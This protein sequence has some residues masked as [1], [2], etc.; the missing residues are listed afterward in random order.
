MG[1]FA[2]LLHPST[3]SPSEAKAKAKSTPHATSSLPP[4][5][6]SPATR[7]GST[8]F[9]T[10]LSTPAPSHTRA[11]SS[12]FP[13][14]PPPPST[15]S[16]ITS[17]I[18]KKPWKKDR[19]K[20]S[21]KGKGKGTTIEDGGPGLGLGMGISDEFGSTRRPI[22]IARTETNYV[23]APS[24]PAPD[25]KRTTMYFAGEAVPS[26]PLSQSFSVS[27]N[28]DDRD[29]A[30][31]NT[32]DGGKRGV[33]SSGRTR[34]QSISSGEFTREG[35]ILGRLTFEDD[36]RLT[37][38]RRDAEPEPDEE[39]VMAV[40]GGKSYNSTIII[41]K[42]DLRSEKPLELSGS[43]VKSGGA[44]EEEFMEVLESAEK[45][46]KFWKGK[47]RARR[48]SKSASDHADIDRAGSPTPR[49]A[50][51]STAAA[52]LDLTVT[53]HSIDLVQPRPQQLRRPSSS[54]FHNPFHRSTSRTSM[55]MDLDKSPVVDDGSFQLKGFRH[56][57]GMMEV[58]GAG[59]LEGYLSHV[60]RE[61]VVA[62]ALDKPTTPA[63]A[64]PLEANSA[65][66]PSS[67][68]MR[69][70]PRPLSRPPSVANSLASLDEYIAS[71]SKV[72][73]AAFRKGIRRPSE[74]ITTMSDIGHGTACASVVDNDDLPLGML[75]KQHPVRQKS[76][77]S[78][79]SMRELGEATD[80]KASASP[81]L[82]FTVQRH[83]LNGGGSPGTSFAVRS[84][85]TTNRLESK[86]ALGPQ[87]EFRP[88]SLNSPQSPHFVGQADDQLKKDGSSRSLSPEA[89]SP[90]DSYFA[91]NAPG[92]TE[93]VTISP[94]FK[95][96]GP[97]VFST[98]PTTITRIIRSPAPLTSPER[99]HPPPVEPIVGP[100][101]GD[102][103]TGSLT[104]PFPPDQ[105]PATPPKSPA[106]LPDLSTEP[107]MSPGGRKRLSLL[108]EPLRI[109]SGLFAS[110]S[111]QGEDGLDPTLVV[112]SMRI[113]GGDT[114]ETTM[115]RPASAQGTKRLD[116]QRSHLT[117]FDA[118][119]ATPGTQG[120][121]ASGLKIEQEGK[122]R[123][124]LSERLAGISS[125]ALNSNTSRA[126]PG[127]KAIDTSGISPER[128]LTDNNMS[129]TSNSTASPPVSATPTLVPSFAGVMIGSRARQ[130]SSS[131][132]ESEETNESIRDRY[133]GNIG[134]AKGASTV[135]ENGRRHPSGPRKPSTASNRNRA[136]YPSSV[137]LT[138]RTSHQHFP[139]RK[140]TPNAHSESDDDEPLATLKYK[141]S[142]S[143]LSVDSTSQSPHVNDQ[144]L[145]VSPV[146]TTTTRIA[147]KARFLPG[148]ESTISIRPV[149]SYDPSASVDVRAR[150][151]LSHSPPEGRR[152]TPTQPQRE[153][154]TTYVTPSHL[155][156]PGTS[157]LRPVQDGQRIRREREKGVESMRRKT[158]SPDSYSS[159]SGTT[160][161]MDSGPYQPMTPKEEKA[162]SRESAGGSPGDGS[163]K[164]DTVTRIGSPQHVSPPQYVDD[165]KRRHSPAPAMQANWP[166]YNSDRGMGMQMNPHMNP[167]AIR[168]IMKQQWQ[169]QFMAAA[170]RASE[171][172][173]ERASS[174]S[175]HSPSAHRQPTTTYQGYGTPPPM[176][177]P[178][179]PG[180]GMS[181]YGGGLSTGYP[182]A[183][184]GY[185]YDPTFV[186]VPL[187]GQNAGG[188]Y[189]YGY[190][191]N[192]QSVFGG[193]FGPPTNLRHHIPTSGSNPNIRTLVDATSLSQ[194]RGHTA[195]RG[196]TTKSVYGGVAA[197]PP[198]PVA[199]T[200]GVGRGRQSTSGEWAG[201]TA[202]QKGGRSKQLIN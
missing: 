3:S 118:G 33:P 162:G 149:R 191:T 161:T 46:N 78:L 145:P 153:Q 144:A 82:S 104:L 4:S 119:T 195:G 127:L 71:S 179:Y 105:M 91:Q 66:S 12:Y 107:A 173:W 9:L 51:A 79:S 30:H 180:M 117:L 7:S 21:G 108:D 57:S 61:S 65:I 186:P 43:S 11:T 2:R 141:A 5:P 122:V 81:A 53:R 185:G 158:A 166:L 131:D 58:E 114:E 120:E 135:T 40:T 64:S 67:T 202:P 32:D 101:P 55:A 26:S 176:P 126:A 41:D 29:D 88:S 121:H 125:L 196:G 177:M 109:I 37:D 189:G 98:P 160:T 31:I 139:I 103:T 39:H 14:T 52:S 198:P 27:S 188:G 172:E 168:E 93:R 133:R 80:R 169:M 159:K 175:A 22:P 136:V 73:V 174:T 90:V 54:I 148:S 178:M 106:Q 6:E 181:P 183:M 84:T 171:E 69:P 92:F 87:T 35:G 143:S 170:Y 154:S 68:S 45:K 182:P 165:S 132:T 77:Q 112:D 156:D 124:P 199:G 134:I 201:L 18:S 17:R 194:T 1:I 99:A 89:Q 56:V 142:R 19:S 10:P 116:P 15:S 85:T 76:S 13:R 150:S 111:S 94:G 86:A 28:M 74:A 72:S 128:K 59:E 23:S 193:E 164:T 115:S 47:G 110:P 100:Q 75:N 25:G 48:L 24:T 42:E 129:P 152:R 44:Q 155:G 8:P 151:R 157:S 34:K 38:S 95:Q 187:P 123:P 16:S 197:S 130:D 192:T 200:W 138:H 190:G 96:S 60:K 49:K 102:N 140:Q 83:K 97:K 63:P 50:S 163:R 70:S 62:L 20:S 137:N 146:S 167:E 147:A 113:L 36:D 184:F